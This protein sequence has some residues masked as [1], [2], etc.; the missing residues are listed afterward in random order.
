MRRHRVEKDAIHIEEHRTQRL[1]PS[2]VM[3]HAVGVYS[4]LYFVWLIHLVCFYFFLPESL[5][6][7]IAIA[8]SPVTL[9]AVPKLSIAMYSEIISAS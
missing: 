2:Q 5:S 7:T 9:H 4:F 6:T 8:P 3:P 1:H